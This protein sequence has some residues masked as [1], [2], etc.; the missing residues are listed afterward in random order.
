MT[1][2]KKLYNKMRKYFYRVMIKSDAY[3]AATYEFEYND[4]NYF[5]AL[6]YAN[7]INVLD[8]RKAFVIDEFITVKK[9]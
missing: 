9:V 2:N 8:D 1:M 5:T 6:M 3:Y 4:Q 7:Y